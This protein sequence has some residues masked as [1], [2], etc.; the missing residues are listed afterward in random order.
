MI[1]V[2]ESTII[3]F[4]NLINNTIQIFSYVILLT[5]EH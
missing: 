4:V 3:H 5:E 2:T 1:S